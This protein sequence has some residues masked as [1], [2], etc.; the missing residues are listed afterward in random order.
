MGYPA[1]QC[2][3]ICEFRQKIVNEGEVM[4][5]AHTE[6]QGHW[7]I[8]KSKVKQQWDKLTEGDLRHIDGQRERLINRIHK[9]YGC[10]PEEA[11]AEVEQFESA[12]EQPASGQGHA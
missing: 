12:M 7:N 5:I 1:S 9:A 2:P 10:S 6:I 11:E 4:K 8:M 3:S